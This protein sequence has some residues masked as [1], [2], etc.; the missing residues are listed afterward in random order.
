MIEYVRKRQIIGIACFYQQP[1]RLN[2]SDEE[3]KHLMEGN[4][5]QEGEGTTTKSKLEQLI[6]MK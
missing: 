3:Q 6:M 4:L 2:N 5:I 1:G